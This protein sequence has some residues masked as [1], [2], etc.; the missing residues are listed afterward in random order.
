MKTFTVRLFVGMSFDQAFGYRGEIAAPADA[1][2]A[3]AEALAATQLLTATGGWTD[4]EN[5]YPEDVTLTPAMIGRARRHPDGDSG[6]DC[7]VYVVDAEVEKR[8]TVQALSKADALL[9]AVEI[10]VTQA[11]S[12]EGSPGWF[13]TDAPELAPITIFAD[14]GTGIEA[15]IADGP[16]PQDDIVVLRLPRTQA[17]AIRSCVAKSA[18]LGAKNPTNARTLLAAIDRAIG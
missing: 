10:A 11:R 9:V 12:D 4:M 3:S 5:A 18:P 16:D 14:T 8:V 13:F 7:I 1:T 2:Q 17:A 15:E 6:L